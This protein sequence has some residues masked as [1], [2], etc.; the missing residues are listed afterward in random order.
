VCCHEALPPLL[1]SHYSAFT[2]GLVRHPQP[3]LLAV[4]GAPGRCP[5]H[6]ECPRALILAPLSAAISRFKILADVEG[7]QGSGSIGV[8]KTFK[9]NSSTHADRHA[10]PHN[11]K[12]RVT[13]Q[14]MTWQHRPP[15]QYYRACS[16][17]TALKAFGTMLFWL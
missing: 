8:E 13:D 2:N 16:L 1:P 15:H 5:W 10:R 7:F 3:W 9:H 11:P 6:S 14:V 17:V 12:P 4:L